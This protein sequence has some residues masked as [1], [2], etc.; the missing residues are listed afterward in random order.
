MCALYQKIESRDAY[1]IKC[2]IE[3]LHG[4]VILNGLVLYL[5]E[6]EDFKRKLHHCCKSPCFFILGLIRVIHLSYKPV[7]TLLKTCLSVLTAEGLG[8]KKKV[9]GGFAPNLINLFFITHCHTL[10]IY[11]L[12]EEIML[13]NTKQKE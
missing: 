1:I 2:V 7:F 5:T 8:V 13:C 3:T 9:V 12:F 11:L 10:F 4:N 6:Q